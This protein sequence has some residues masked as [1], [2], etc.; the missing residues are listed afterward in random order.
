MP[1]SS[2]TLDPR[3]DGSLC[4]LPKG[5]GCSACCAQ[6]Q[7]HGTPYPSPLP[8]P[9]NYFK[10]EHRYSTPMNTHGFR[11]FQFFFL[12]SGHR[13]RDIDIL[14]AQKGGVYIYDWK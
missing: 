6:P 2:D 10:R 8:F 13:L 1:A 11:K 9:L 14:T 4:T 3:A 12:V 7:I 5:E